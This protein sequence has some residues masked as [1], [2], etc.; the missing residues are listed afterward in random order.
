MRHGGGPLEARL[1]AHSG[2]YSDVSTSRGLSNITS[3]RYQCIC[4]HH[5][6][7][8]S[9]KRSAC[10]PQVANRRSS[11]SNIQTRVL[12]STRIMNSYEYYEQTTQKCCL[13]NSVYSVLLFCALL[14][15]ALP[16]TFLPVHFPSPPPGPSSPD[17]I[18]FPS[19]PHPLRLSLFHS[20]PLSIRSSSPPHHLPSWSRPVPSPSLHRPRRARNGMGGKTLERNSKLQPV[21]DASVLSS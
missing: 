17:S 1:T 13:F 7:F 8:S 9:S 15:S 10:C 2:F 6:V 19:H 4:V 21:Y 18:P 3:A 12:R 5:S 14:C 20:H 16:I 11:S